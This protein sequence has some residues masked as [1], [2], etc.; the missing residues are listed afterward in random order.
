MNKIQKKTPLFD[1]IVNYANLKR[2]SFHTP[3][4]KNGKGNLRKIKEFI[5]DK[6]FAMDLSVSVRNKIDSLDKPYGAIKEAQKLAASLYNASHSF[7]LVNGTTI[8]NQV[9]I[10]STLSENDKVIL[11]RNVHRSVI[12]GI[13]LSGAIPYYIY[14]EINEKFGILT[15]ITYN[16]VKLALKQNHLAKAILI[17]NPSYYGITTDLVK[18]VDLVHKDNKIILID[19]AH[20]P[21][22]KFHPDL[23]L[24]AIDS[25][26]DMC[27]QSTHKILAC[28]SQGS[29]LHLNSSKIDLFRL[30]QTLQLLQTTSP[31]YIILATLDL[32]RMQMAIF[33]EK[34]LNVVIE[35]AENLREKINKIDGFSCLTKQD[36][37]GFNLD[38]TKIT[39]LHKNLSGFELAKILADEFGIQV[40]LA[41]YTNILLM[42]TIG[43]KKEDINKL[44]LALQKISKS[45]KN[46]KIKNLFLTKP[47]IPKQVLTPRKAMLSKK[48]FIPIKESCGLICG[49]IIC[50]YP[51]GIPILFPGEMITQEIIKYIENIIFSGGEVNGWTKN[52][53]LKI[54]VVK[55]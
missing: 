40:E 19:E 42:I 28:L 38:V 11:P 4:H 44:I 32:A 48:D 13:I 29:I 1:A 24:S 23:P 7:F 5:G 34:L 8:G 30:K 37:P 15:N 18:I 41:N 22:L 10:F 47:E 26:V 20:G 55:A 51:P 3:G 33:G 16:Q 21:H 53:S 25:G 2:I 36:I 46:K 17:T 14:P 35:L 27:V 50:S 49:E 54:Q 9:M 6:I 12:S 45:C 52:K 43:N 39:I 31:S